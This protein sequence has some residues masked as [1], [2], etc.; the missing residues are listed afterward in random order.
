MCLGYNSQPSTTSISN[1][2]TL[3]NS[4]IATLRCQVTTITSLSDARDKKDI[5][6]LEPSLEFIEQ[7]NPV[8]FKWN[9]RDGGKV[10]IPEIGFIAQELQKVQVDSGIHIPGLV[11]DDNPDK[12]EASYGTLLPLLVK[13]IQ[14]L[15]Q[16]V[17]DLKN[18]LEILKNIK[19]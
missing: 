16:K 9:M 14:E 6:N 2:I 4:S 1:Q 17:K 15:S 10:D 18:E 11:Y 7:L 8:R 12:L 19:E 5:V 3:G 13:S